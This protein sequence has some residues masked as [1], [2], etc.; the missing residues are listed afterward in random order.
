MK[1]ILRPATHGV[2]DYLAVAAFAAAPSLV[3]LSG[4]AAAVSYTLAAAHLLLTLVTAFPLGA[5]KKF[6]FSYHGVLEF[7]AGILIIIFSF[8]GS[9]GGNARWFFLAMGAILLGSFF[10]TDY[11]DL[12]VKTA[13][14]KEKSAV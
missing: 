4:L 8:A 13:A 5:V 9:G 7:Y 11:Q 10:V 6:S 2:L 12:A 3:P 1:K 14:L